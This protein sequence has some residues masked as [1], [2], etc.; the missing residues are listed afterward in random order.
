MCFYCY[1][2]QFHLRSGI[3]WCQYRAIILDNDSSFAVLCR[4]LVKFHCYR[5]SVYRFIHINIAIYPAVLEYHRCI[6]TAVDI[7]IAPHSQVF[8]GHF[9]VCNCRINIQIASY[10][11]VLQIHAIRCHRYM[12]VCSAAAVR[13]YT[14]TSISSARTSPIILI[15][16]LWFICFLFRLYRI[17]SD[18]GG[19]STDI[20]CHGINVTLTGNCNFIINIHIIHLRIGK[21][22][23]C[24]ISVF[25]DL[26][27][28]NLCVREQPNIGFGIQCQ[29]AYI[30]INND[31]AGKFFLNH[32][33]LIFAAAEF[34]RFSERCILNIGF[35]RCLD[36]HI[37]LVQYQF[38]NITA[39]QRY[40]TAAVYNQSSFHCH[41]VQRHRFAA[42]TFRYRQIPSNGFIFQAI[43]GQRHIFC[44]RFILCIRIFV[45]L[46]ILSF[47]LHRLIQR[48]HRFRSGQQIQRTKRSIRIPCHNAGFTDTADLPYR[49][50]GHCG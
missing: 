20:N 4:R 48:Y 7:H 49:P 16:I 50:A 26:K 42:Q 13:R 8:C 36:G 37:L 14:D 12:I 19:Y 21:I 10:G 22:N 41:I 24:P 3:R 44:I 25:G 9:A 43:F 35:T 31:I 32:N 23:G 29:I 5:F 28:A 11:H 1:F 30:R 15:R 47:I 18:T 33:R 27:M 39:S 2:G 34:R 6:A 17:R 40:R 45:I 46:R 38:I